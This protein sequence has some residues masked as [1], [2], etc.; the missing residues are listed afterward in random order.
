MRSKTCCT[1]PEESAL[2]VAAKYGHTDL[3]RYIIHR[4]NSFS[5][6]LPGA[7]SML[8][9]EATRDN[10]IHTERTLVVLGASCDILDAN[11]K[12]ALHV[13][14]EKGNLE[15]TKFIVERQEISYGEA[16]L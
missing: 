12:T 4:Q 9:H 10:H 2:R 5:M 16:E 1:N 7:S 8:L 13:S 11:G 15:V 14:A 6:A 3:L